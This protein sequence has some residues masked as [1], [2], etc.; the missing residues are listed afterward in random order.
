MAWMID[1]KPKTMG[2]AV[3]VWL[4]KGYFQA[5]IQFVTPAQ[6]GSQ[7]KRQRDS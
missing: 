5:L 2:D 6:A 7:L 3:K 4:D 1:G